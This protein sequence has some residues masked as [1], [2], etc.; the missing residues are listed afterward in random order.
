MKRWTSI[1]LE[2]ARHRYEQWTVVKGG[3]LLQKT[4]LKLHTVEKRINGDEGQ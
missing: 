2:A 3:L 4:Q 1:S